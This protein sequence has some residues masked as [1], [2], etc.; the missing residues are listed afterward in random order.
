MVLELVRFEPPRLLL[1]DVP[2]EIEHVLGDFDVLDVVEIL[3]LRAHF[4]W[5]A[6]QRSH[7]SLVQ[8]LQRYDVLAIG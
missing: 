2:G 1:H 3:C 7:Q 6:Q 4:V 5:V 8:R